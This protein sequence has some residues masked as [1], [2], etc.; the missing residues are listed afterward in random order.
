MTLKRSRHGQTVSVSTEERFL[1]TSGDMPATLRA[2]QDERPARPSTDWDPDE[3]LATAEADIIEYVVAKYSVQCPVLHRDRIE[4]LP[5][6]EDSPAQPGERLHRPRLSARVT[7]IVIGVPFDGEEDV[8]KLPPSI[9][10][11][12]PPR[13]RGIRT[14]ELRLS[15]LGAQGSSAD[16]VPPTVRRTSTTNSTGSSSSWLGAR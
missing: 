9:R 1:F 15:G 4:G 16:V 13:R 7:K 2:Q 3:L 5:V 10:A 6:S 8:F 12:S 11:F 14:G